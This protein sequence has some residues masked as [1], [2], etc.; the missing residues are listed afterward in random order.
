MPN[1]R[2][3]QELNNKHNPKWVNYPQITTHRG[4]NRCQPLSHLVQVKADDQSGTVR[5]WFLPTTDY[6]RVFWIW[7]CLRF[8]DL[9]APKGLCAS[10]IGLRE[11]RIEQALPQVDTIRGLD[12]C[13]DAATKFVGDDIGENNGRCI[14]VDSAQ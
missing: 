1:R 3:N 6:Q 11:A 8:A 2:L 4:S 14:V 9:S 13:H 12:L 5:G 7:L 10:V